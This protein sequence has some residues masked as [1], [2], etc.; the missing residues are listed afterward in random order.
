MKITRETETLWMIR[1]VEKPY[2]WASEI[3]SWQLPG[4][5]DCVSSY[6]TLGIYVNPADFDPSSLENL[7]TTNP[8]KPTSHQVYVCYE[9]GPDLNRVCDTLGI[10]HRQFIDMHTA[11]TYTCV[12]LGFCP[13]FAYLEGL[14]DRISG[15]PRLKTPRL[16][17]NP[18]S[19]GITG[20]QTAVYPSMR[21]G[22]WNLIGVTPQTLVDPEAS[23]FPIRAGDVLRFVSIHA[24][25]MESYRSIRL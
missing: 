10:S 5:L 6:N 8:T 21:P 23:Y 14:D 18:G 16:A 19:V 11:P 24:G 20:D 25:E 4:V 13:G 12:G 3:E 9:L 1:E 7:S 17:V 22:G 15:L 2:L